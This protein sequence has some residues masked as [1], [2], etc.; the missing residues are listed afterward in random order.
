MI[1]LGTEGG[2]SVDDSDG[3][4]LIRLSTEALASR[5]KSLEV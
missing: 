3:Y 5:V 2:L 1:F 4:T